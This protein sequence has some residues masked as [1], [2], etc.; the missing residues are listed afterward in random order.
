MTRENDNVVDNADY[1][2]EYQSKLE[3]K[4]EDKE[5]QFQ[6]FQK[7]PSIDIINT[8]TEERTQK[9]KESRENHS[10]IKGSTKDLNESKKQNH[11][12]LNTPIEPDKNNLKPRES[13]KQSHVIVNSHKEK[14]DIKPNQILSIL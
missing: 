9:L 6:N 2:N 3:F 5:T 8:K 7:R 1:T 14:E 13:I 10:I 11:V 12:I 4:Q